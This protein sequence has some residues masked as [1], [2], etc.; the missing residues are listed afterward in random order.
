M[1]RLTDFYGAQQASK[2]ACGGETTDESLTGVGG[3]VSR[4]FAVLGLAPGFDITALADEDIRLPEHLVAC[5]GRIFTCSLT[6]CPL[7]EALAY[8]KAVLFDLLCGENSHSGLLN[9]VSI[10]VPSTNLNHENGIGRLTRLW[11]CHVQWLF[12]CF[13]CSRKS[14]SINSCV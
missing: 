2:D 5:I 7:R 10:E 14:E 12:K 8:L 9:F 11:R 4:A 6:G 13:K 1:K 3:N